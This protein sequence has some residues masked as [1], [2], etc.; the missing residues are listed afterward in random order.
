M[1]PDFGGKPW[2]LVHY[3]CL[4]SAVERIRPTDVLFHCEYEP[5]GAWWELTRPLVTVEK[6]AAPREVF[7]NPLL[8]GAHRADVVRLET[9]LSAGGIYLDADVFVHRSFDELLKYQ[10]VLGEE[11]VSGRVVG[12]CNAIILAEANAPFLRRW[13]S[14]YSWFRSKGHDR[15]WDEHSVRVPYELSK[16]FSHDVTVLPYTAFYWPTFEAEGISSIFD[17]ADPIDLSSAYANHL[18]ESPA[19]ERYLEDLTPRRVR[20]EN[21]NFHYWARPVVEALAD[22]YGTPVLSDRLAHGVR[23]A[24]RRVRRILHRNRSTR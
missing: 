8:H 21:T 23:G 9:L 6:T 1:S 10:T 12:L 3:V 2:S 15:Y 14:E 22:N 24:R 7:G 19:W 18:W 11:R 4:K 13:H 20:S 5:T 16:S 17:C